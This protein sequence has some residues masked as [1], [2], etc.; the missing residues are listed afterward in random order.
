MVLLMV[1]I[2]LFGYKYLFASEK[3]VFEA[4]RT[5][6]KSRL[7]VLEWAW[8]G[9][10]GEGSGIPHFGQRRISDSRRSSELE[11]STS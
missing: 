9:S 1:D 10:G 4:L 11:A 8:W 5:F 6:R 2:Y 3:G 7:K